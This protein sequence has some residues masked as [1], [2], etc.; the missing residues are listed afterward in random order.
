ML[1]TIGLMVPLLQRPL[2]NPYAT[3]IILFMN[4]VEE[5]I[6]NED[7]I[8]DLTPYSPTT[9]RLLKY[10]PPKGMHPN[11]VHSSLSNPEVVRFSL[12]RDSVT[13]FDHIFD[14]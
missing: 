6:T 14:R 10:L 1:R 5:N 4:A 7:R 3:L 8:A 11:G 2:I 12:A 13:T 9:K